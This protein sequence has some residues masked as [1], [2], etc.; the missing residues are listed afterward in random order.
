[1]SK[2]RAMTKSTNSSRHSPGKGAALVWFRRD[3]RLSD[4]EALHAAIA[5]GLPVLCLYIHNDGDAAGDRPPGSASR[6]WLSRSLRALN[7]RLVEIG[8][9]LIVLRGDPCAVLRRVAR[10][11]GVSAVFFNRRYERAALAVD[12]AVARALSDEGVR[13]EVSGGS[14]LNEPWR[15][16]TKSGT[17]IKVFGAFERAA[18]AVGEPPPPLP[19]PAR[20]EDAGHAI[21]GDAIDDLKLEPSHPDWAREMTAL[22]TPGESGAHDLL[23]RFTDDALDGY[24]EGRERPALDATTRLSPY[25]QQGEISPRQLWHAIGHAAQGGAAQR[26]VERF[27]TELTWR[28]FAYHVL[29]HEPHLHERNHRAQFDGMAWQT[30]RAALAAWKGGMTGYPIVDAGMRQLW[31]LGW[32]HNRVRMITASFLVKHLLIDWRVGESWFW[33]TLVDADPANNPFNWQW[34]AGSGYDASPFFRIFNPVTQG[35]RHDPQ[36]DYVRRFVPEL[37]GLPAKFIHRPWDAPPAVLRAAGIKLGDTY[38]RP[39]VDHAAA[40]DRALAA[41]KALRAPDAAD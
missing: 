25:L 14:L 32:M 17:P 20:I 29:F 19:A 7:Q 2:N 39:V 34:V 40:R 13:V 28:E 12:E 35:E 21:A 5:S 18:R 23:A 11:A 33:D 26:H 37:D 10:D 38:P 9:R 22:W 6:W 36:G 3:L 15:L 41:F 16:K 24:A 30:D 8:G 27:L 31:R 4:N 1:M